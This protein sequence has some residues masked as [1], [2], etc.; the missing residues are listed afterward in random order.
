[1]TARIT[2]TAVVLMVAAA[3]A[4][5]QDNAPAVPA[6]LK[7]LDFL[8]GS[9]WEGPMADGKQT[10][11]HCTRWVMGGRY[12]RDTIRIKDANPPQGG[13]TTYYWDLDAKVV[14]Y[15]YLSTV[16]ATSAGT[17]RFEGDAY[18]FD[19][20]R[21]VGR[22]GIVHF[23]TRFTRKGPDR[24]VQSGRR[25]GPDGVWKDTPATTFVRKPL[26]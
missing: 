24:Y 15:I 9:C 10:L 11:Q 14:R 3:T 7:P 19:D 20:E 5:A 23:R 22:S 21:L 1:M 18:V 17:V 25:Q 26:E 16:G 2:R 4:S 6:E 12:L 13:E 8:A